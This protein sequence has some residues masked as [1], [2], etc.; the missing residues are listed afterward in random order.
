MPLLASTLDFPLHSDQESELEQAREAGQVHR[1]KKLLNIFSSRAERESYRELLRKMDARLPRPLEFT[2]CEFERGFVLS[3]KGNN[4]YLMVRLFSKGHRYWSRIVLD[5]GVVLP[6]ECGREYHESE[7]LEHGEPKSAKLLIRRNDEGL[8]EFFVHISFEFKPEPVETTTFL[9][10][11]RGSVRIGAGTIVDREAQIVIKGL[12]LEGETFNREQ[13]DFRRRIAESQSKGQRAPRLFRLRR[14][15]ADIIVGEYAN[16]IVSAALE[17]RSQIVIEDI[18]A[19][20]MRMFLSTSQFDKLRFM[21]DYK[22][23]RVGL[24]KPVAV[25]AAYTSQTCARC[26]CKDRSN[27]PHRNAEGKTR[28]RP[29][30]R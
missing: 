14:R 17:H 21:L 16:R 8:E 12:D 27:R 6:L 5:S 26:G 30:L 13:A 18:N 4:L 7:Y 11:D 25:P 22:A 20:A 1:V 10:I 23:E 19:K 9:G 28:N 29:E 3:K 24:P 2:R 15:R